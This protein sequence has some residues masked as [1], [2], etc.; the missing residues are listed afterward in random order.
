MAGGRML[1]FPT[2]DEIREVGPEHVILDGD[3]GQYDAPYFD[4]A[5]AGY[6]EKLSAF[7]SEQELSMMV[8]ENPAQLLNT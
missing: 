2:M 8:R 5:M 4:D 6:L 7:F 1:W 3:F